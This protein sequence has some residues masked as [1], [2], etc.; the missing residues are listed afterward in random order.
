MCL[1][2]ILVRAR[3]M[4]RS[5]TTASTCTTTGTTLQPLVRVL[6]RP[7]NPERFW[8]SS[9]TQIYPHHPSDLHGCMDLTQSRYEVKPYF[10]VLFTNSVAYV[11]ASCSQL[12][13]SE[14]TNNCL[15]RLHSC[16]YHGHQEEG[17]ECNNS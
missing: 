5:T 9:L 6:R 11:K 17:A 4:W 8:M 15:R 3:M 12:I 13:H 10:T 2:L 7:S 14:R 16:G 1:Y